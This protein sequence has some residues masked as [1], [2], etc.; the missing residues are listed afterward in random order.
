[1]KGGTC[2]KWD[3]TEARMPLQNHSQHKK[4]LYI[5]PT[6]RFLQYLTQA[7]ATWR[8]LSN[9][10]HQSWRYRSIAFAH[11]VQICWSVR[12]CKVW[13]RKEEDI[14]Y[15][16]LCNSPEK[17]IVVTLRISQNLKSWIRMWE[18]SA[19][20]NYKNKSIVPNRFRVFLSLIN[21]ICLF[22]HEVIVPTFL[23]PNM[24]FSFIL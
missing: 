16:D 22:I 6:L 13:Q 9:W 18:T 12:W 7:R 17:Q 5:Q 11:R 10:H 14:Q 21:K 8:N 1:M 19:N 24:E 20:N 4:N 3:E 23:Y 15:C 2:L